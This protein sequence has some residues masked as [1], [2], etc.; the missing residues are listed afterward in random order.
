MPTGEITR[1]THRQL[2]RLAA[3]LPAAG[4]FSR[5]RALAAPHARKIKITAVKDASAHFGA[6]IHNFY[7]SEGAL[8]R[9]SRQVEELVTS[10]PEVRNGQ[11]KVPTRP[12]L[13]LD[14]NE[15]ALRRRLMH[16]EP[17]WG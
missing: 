8:G 9:P 4:T 10:P 16:G 11:L 7:R 12:G 6:A 5:Y 17:W 1:L 3:T 15:D 14:F 13:G 2:L